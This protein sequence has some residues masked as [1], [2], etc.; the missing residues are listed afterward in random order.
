MLKSFFQCVAQFVNV[1]VETVVESFT[2]HWAAIEIMIKSLT[3]L[4]PRIFLTTAKYAVFPLTE[5]P[6]E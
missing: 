6:W 5:K 3:K 4:V 1:R 2:T